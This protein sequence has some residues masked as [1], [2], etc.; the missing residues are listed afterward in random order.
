MV[1]AVGGKERARSIMRNRGVNGNPTISQGPIL[2]IL[3]PSLWATFLPLLCP[4]DR[5]L[6]S[7]DTFDV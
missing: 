2:V 7:F 4:F 1:G 5:F 6:P 3:P